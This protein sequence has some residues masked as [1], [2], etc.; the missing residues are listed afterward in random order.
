MNLA[1]LT[2]TPDNIHQ[3]A[4]RFDISTDE[5]STALNALLPAFS[6]G[7]KRNA[8]SAQ[9]AA[10][11]I[12]ALASGQHQGYAADPAN[13]VSDSGMADGLAILGHLF[14]NK[15]VSR[16][17]ADH[18]A[19]HTGLGSSLLKQML[20]VIAS[21]VMGS[22]FKGASSGRQGNRAGFGPSTAQLGG[23]GGLGELLGQVLGGGG[24]ASGGQAQGQGSGG[25]IL[26]HILEGLA[27][28]ALSGTRQPRRRTRTRRR[29]GRQSRQPGL[30][31]ILG[32]LLGGGQSGRQTGGSRRRRRRLP[33]DMDDM[34]PPPRRQR[35]PRA[36][37]QQP[38]RTSPSSGG[39]IFDELFGGGT[40]QRRPRRRTTRHDY[41]G[42]DTGH[43]TQRSRRA[44][45]NQG[46]LENIFGDLLDSGTTADPGY[47]KGT[48]DVFDQL[49][50]PSR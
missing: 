12:R 50:G 4:R 17:V 22:L 45:R 19:T 23:V 47:T 13:A 43:R 5:A 34:M 26:G 6:T 30:E 32:E 14:G 39:S 10:G 42:Y 38:N 1:Q 18:A 20:P 15:N 29:Q 36:P 40:A 28:G 35:R 33:A 7:L 37:R 27:G 16:G 25:G 21:M 48:G 24:L 11:L 44:P 9:G 31:D 2:I 49:L 8:A 46:G 3:L 41:D